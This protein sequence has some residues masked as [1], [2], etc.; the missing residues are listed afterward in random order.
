LSE[1]D[2]LLACVD[3]KYTQVLV[4]RVVSDLDM[5]LPEGKVRPAGRKFKL[6]NVGDRKL[7]EEIGRFRLMNAH[8]TSGVSVG[9]YR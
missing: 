9:A 5:A 6:D 7:P 4:L 1:G 8:A 2:E 3:R